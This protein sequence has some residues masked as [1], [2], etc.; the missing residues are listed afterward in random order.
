MPHSKRFK[1][2]K[3]NIKK[4]SLLTLGDAVKLVKTN[5]TAKFDESIEIHMSLGI[6]PK[7][8]EQQ[9]R[10]IVSLPHGTGKKTR[11]IAFVDA[12][13]EQVA[14]DAGADIIGNEEYIAKLVQTGIIEFDVAVAT[15][16][17][18]TKL[19][20]AARILGPRGLMPNPKTDTVGANVTKMIEEQKAGKVSFKNDNTSNIHMTI[21][22]ASFT[23]EKIL[24]NAKTAID[25]VKKAK[26]ASAKGIYIKSAYITST[27]GPAIRLDVS[28]L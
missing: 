16:A 11:I 2:A 19:A 26:P 14:K 1:E 25:A 4:D 8:S 20:K 22:K 17:M 3:K 24:D 9:I 18:M 10:P 21:A 13:Q 7:Q 6:D 5:A 15:P 27:M 23:E 28:S 12:T